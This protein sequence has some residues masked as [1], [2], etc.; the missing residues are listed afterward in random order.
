LGAPL[1]RLFAKGALLSA[2]LLVGALV[3]A[4]AAL[5]VLGSGYS[6]EGSGLLR[7]LL[8]GLIGRA[9][10]VAWMSVN[11]VWRRTQRVLLVQLA[12]TG[13]MVG[14]TALL[15]WAGC[16]LTAI[17]LLYLA[18]HSAGALLLAPG[19]HRATLDPGRSAS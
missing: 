4:P 1:R 11:R 5:D 3:L 6:E 17:G 18:V 12:L 2:P 14:G 9:V 15:M 8:L 13:S 19:L 16:S 7:L 10:V